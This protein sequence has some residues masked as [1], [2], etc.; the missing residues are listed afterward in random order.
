MECDKDFGL[1][2]QKSKAETPSD[3]IDVLRSSRVKPAPFDVEETNQQ[4]FRC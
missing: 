2:N 1:V 3:W 4:Y